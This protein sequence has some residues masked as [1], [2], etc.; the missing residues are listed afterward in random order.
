VK[1]A[2]EY[3]PPDKQDKAEPELRTLE[4][5]KEE[6]SWGT[7]E[8]Q[9]PAGREGKY[10]FRLTK[11]DVSAAQPDKKQPSAEAVVELPPGELDKLRLNYQELTQAADT[12]I[13]KF[14]SLAKADNLL[15][16]LPLGPSIAISSQVPPTLLWN[17]WLAFVGVLFL[18]TSE[19]ILRKFKHL[20]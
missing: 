2:V 15:D 4:L 13:G 5:A 7:Y 6:R 11:P 10:R 17:H 8:G 14:Y 19:W 18:I 16:D 3:F 1:V 12:T 9:W 20:L